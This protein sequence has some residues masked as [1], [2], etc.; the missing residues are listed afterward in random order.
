MKQAN[1]TV[2]KLGG[3]FPEKQSIILKKSFK[4]SIKHLFLDSKI[5]IDEF[6]AETFYR[7]RTSEFF[8]I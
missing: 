6:T 8:N 1:F 3:N 5:P 2:K 7:I 4:S